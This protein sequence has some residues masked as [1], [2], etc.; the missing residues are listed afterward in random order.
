[1]SS[2][3]QRIVI[4]LK[5]VI[6]DSAVVQASLILAIVNK[7]LCMPSQ[8]SQRDS[9]LYW[10]KLTL[11]FRYAELL[12]PNTSVIINAHLFGDLLG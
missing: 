1:M 9:D 12:C 8:H 5:A 6:I 2:F 3:S 10:N 7:C 11:L 4:N